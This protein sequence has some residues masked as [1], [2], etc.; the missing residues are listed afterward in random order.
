MVQRSV[1]DLRDAGEPPRGV[2]CSTGPSIHHQTHDRQASSVC[3]KMSW[4][5]QN[6][7][8]DRA[9]GVGQMSNSSVQPCFSMLKAWRGSGGETLSEAHVPAGLVKGP[10]NRSNPIDF[11]VFGPKVLTAITAD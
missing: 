4:E 1:A 2:S 6:S 7:D 11:T 10:I 8:E 5:G 9:S 3:K